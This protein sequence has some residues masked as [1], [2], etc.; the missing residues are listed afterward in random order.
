MA[1]ILN[2]ALAPHL[3]DELVTAM[4]E[5]P[6]FLSVDAYSNIGLSKLNPLTVRI[7]DVN[8]Q[9]VSQIFLDLSLTTGVD[10]SKTKDIFKAINN[11]LEK[12]EKPCDH[13]VAFGIYNIN[14]NI[15]AKS[16]IKSR[17]TQVNLSTLFCWVPLPHNSYCSTKS[18]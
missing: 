14:S 3:R 2:Y 10:A 16:S 12:Y 5:E 11:T 15:G 18:F 4:K 6:Y 8:Q 9:V 13:C 7:Y 1:C 17:I